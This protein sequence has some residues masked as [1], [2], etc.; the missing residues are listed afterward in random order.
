MNNMGTLEE[1]VWLAKRALAQV[2]EYTRD[3][4][5][6]LECIESDLPKTKEMENTREQILSCMD[7]L[8]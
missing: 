3:V 8:S 1:A 6:D 4:Y 7:K 5:T 2:D